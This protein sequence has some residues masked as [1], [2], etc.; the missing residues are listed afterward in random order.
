[1]HCWLS[2]YLRNAIFLLAIKK[3]LH[4]IGV[5]SYLSFSSS[6][7]ATPAITTTITI[8]SPGEMRQILYQNTYF[9]IKY[10]FFYYSLWEL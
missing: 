3:A 5:R 4:F 8:N 7:I 10:S 2:Y 9:A 1:M 6:N